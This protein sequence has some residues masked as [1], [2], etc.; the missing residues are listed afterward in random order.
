MSIEF[1]QFVREKEAELKRDFTIAEISEGS[2]ISENTIKRLLRG[3]VSRIDQRTIDG[4]CRFFDVPNGPVPFVI[5]PGAN[6]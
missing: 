6:K 5:Y 2:G 4:L 1:A 3:R